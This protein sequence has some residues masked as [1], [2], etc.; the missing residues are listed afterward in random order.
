MG[1]Q[2]LKNNNSNYEGENNENISR[3]YNDTQE[4]NRSQTGVPRSHSALHQNN[5]ANPSNAVSHQQAPSDVSNQ[6]AANRLPLIDQIV[7]DVST[8]P[9]TD[10]KSL[11]NQDGESAFNKIVMN[12]QQYLN[13]Q[14]NLANNVKHS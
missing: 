7:G 1:S 4:S 2:N 3:I 8:N 13:T 9:F 5:Y 11:V 14:S 12:S 10:K 6:R